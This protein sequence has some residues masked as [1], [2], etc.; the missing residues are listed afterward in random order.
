[1]KHRDDKIARAAHI[2]ARTE[3]TSNEISFSVLDAAK[4][5]IDNERRRFS[6]SEAIESRQV[7][8]AETLDVSRETSETEPTKR[9]RH[10]I[11]RKTASESD[12]EAKPKRSTRNRRSIKKASEHA[13]RG[14]SHEKRVEGKRVSLEEEIARRKSR[15]R[16]GRIAALSVVFVT[17]LVIIAVAV[18]AWHVDTTEQQSYEAQLMRS[19]EMISR[20]DDEVLRCD[21][22]IDDPF[23]SENKQLKQSVLDEVSDTQDLLEDADTQARQASDSLKDPVVKNIANQTVISVSARQ[24]MLQQAVT[25]VSAS[26]ETDAAA[27]ECKEIW[28]KVLNADDVT[29]EASKLV[30]ADD[31]ASSK[32]KTLQAKNMFEESLSMLQAFQEKHSEVDLSAAVAYVQKRVEAAEYAVAADDALLDRNKEEAIAQN[33]LYNQAESDAAAIAAKFP[34]DTDQLFHDAYSKQNADLLKAYAAKR[35]EAGTSDAVIRD[36]L[37]AQG[38]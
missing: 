18:W 26:A 21:A 29:H 36:Y 27:Q 23:S 9:S 22:I 6:L 16:L 35:A 2:K 13:R 1:M 12:S 15:R 10:S 4:Y 37:G 30:E 11:K 5:A 17:S 20:A 24:T 8:R 32:E 3:G 28:S 14:G 19:L 31:P 25:L 33:D 38:K 7:R 34:S